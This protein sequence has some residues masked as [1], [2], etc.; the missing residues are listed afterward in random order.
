MLRT[1]KVKLDLWG[2]L[3]VGC[4]RENLSSSIMSSENFCLDCKRMRNEAKGANSSNLFR[5]LSKIISLKIER[6]LHD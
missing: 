6:E 2:I 5:V 4:Q 3:V 1:G